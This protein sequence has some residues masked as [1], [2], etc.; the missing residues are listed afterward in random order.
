MEAINQFFR[1]N[2]FLGQVGHLILL[3]AITLVVVV[4]ILRAQNRITAKLRKGKASLNARLVDNG[5]KFLLIFLAIQ[6]VM[7]SSELTKN[8][9]QTLFQG[10]AVLAAIAG[11]AAQNVLADILCGLIISTT[12]PFEIGNRISLESGI[13]GIVVDMT[14]RHVVLR[15]IDTQMYVVP[16]S[17][18]N[19]EKITN[20]SWQTETRSVDFRFLVAYTSDPDRARAVIRQAVMDSPLSVPGKPGKDGKEYADVYFL[21]MEEYS[22]QM[23]TTAY[24]MPGTPTEVFRTDINTRVKNALASNGIEIPY[25]YINVQMKDGSGA[26]F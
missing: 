20:L 6:F 11:F 18:M 5:F 7:M 9:G 8:F 24:Y 3:S 14:L 19:A 12:K 21:S 13:S 26:E 1:D 23:G 4:L 10:T 16:N 15:G 22:L 2:P 25:R 17:K